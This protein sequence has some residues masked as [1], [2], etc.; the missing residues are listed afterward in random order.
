MTVAVTGTGADIKTGWSIAGV[1]EEVKVLQRT[2]TFDNSYAAGGEP[3][4]AA[5]F[6]LTEILEVWVTQP[7]NYEVWFDKA[8]ATLQVNGSGGIGG[9]GI[10]TISDNDSAATNGVAVYAHA[11]SA[12]G[13][14]QA[15]IGHLEFVSPTDAD[16]RDTS[17]VISIVVNDDDAAA[18]AGAAVFAAP[19]GAGLYANVGKDIKIPLTDGEFFQI[20][21]DAD[22][23]SNQTAVQLY[24]DEDGTLGSRFQVVA[25]DNADETFLFDTTL[26]WRGGSPSG[27]QEIGGATDLSSLAVRLMVIG[28]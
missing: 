1:S 23:A 12:G 11:E 8:A 17:G 2:V 15:D 22:P 14:S 25:V 4:T 9:A 18:T 20:T 5:M 26:D 10:W 19:A 16:G 21:H 28:Y 13:S 7:E 24:F 6:G 27:N 3:I